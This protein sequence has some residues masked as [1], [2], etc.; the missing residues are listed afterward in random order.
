MRPV[1]VWQWS[2]RGLLLCLLCSLCL[3][4]PSP[5]TD[6]EKRAESQGLRF[7]LAGFPRKPYE[8]R[9]EIQR[10]GE[11]G[12]ICD[13]DFTLQAAHVLCRELG[14]TEATGWTHS[15]KYG[16]GTGRIWLDNLSCRG[17]EQSVTECA[18]RGWGNS[19]CT[20]DEDAG[21]ICKD[22]R[23]PGFSDSNVIEGR[24]RLKGGAHPGEGRVEVLKASTWGTVC[25]RKWDL[26]AASVVCRELG[27]G[28]AREA[29]SGARM[30]QGM[31]AIHLS[32]VRCS[33]QELSLWKCPHKN[34]TAE[35]CSHSQDAGV[36]CNLPYTGVETRIRLSGGRSQ[37]EGRVEVQIG[38][39]GSLRWG[40]ICGDDWGT[41]EAM[42]ACRQLGL[43]YANHGLQETWYWDSGNITEVV[44]SGVRC[45][46]TELS[47]DQCAHHGT[48]LAC[49]R[50]GTRFTA[51]VICSET[52]SDLL[53]H[54]A[55]VQET[56]YIE[57]RPLH[58]LYCAAEENC[59]ASSARSANWP[60]GHR[61]LLRFSSQIHNLGRADFR[62]KA[63]R[64]SWVW[65]ECHGHYHSMDIFTHY[66]ILTANGTK[67]AEGHKASFCLEDTECQ[68]DV[69]KRYECANFGEQ[70]ITV[71]CWDL[72]RHDIDC[73]WIDITDVKPGNYI[74]QVV[75]N[76]NFEV[77]ESDFTNNA[78]K[79]NC[80]YDGHRIWVHN[81]HIGDAFSEEA[82]RR[83]ERYP[84]QTS[85]Q[86][87]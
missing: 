87:I 15:A 1:S 65:H 21:V 16:P 86:I 19:D 53:L 75:I 26:H 74:L 82:N 2:A 23:L 73:Q 69:S 8:G 66:D 59:L 61:R 46:G 41:L 39:P 40:L 83:F 30:G 4:S 33:G 84:G 17:T 80:K 63:G 56:A 67:V 50:T 62:P 48:H 81:C 31:G 47:L 9:V 37:H 52:A 24:V 49:K 79:C 45:T 54:S 10:A 78:M 22:Q 28:S 55:L 58:M 51:G 12:T 3:G 27:F 5:S 25:D 44:M 68:E 71:G 42:V 32:E 18:S 13:D 11:W 60:Y 57:D 64:H 14:F 85:N 20:H 34:I 43:G 72:Y 29:L 35:D 77:A 38:G 6:P 70:G 36:R 76:P 7:R